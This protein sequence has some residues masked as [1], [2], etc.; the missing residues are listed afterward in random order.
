MP[1]EWLLYMCQLN[2]PVTGP[3]VLC[4]ET[5][6]ADP[7]QNQKDWLISGA[8]K[9]KDWNRL[10]QIP[11]PAVTPLSPSGPHLHTYPS[12]LCNICPWMQKLILALQMTKTPGDVMLLY[13]SMIPHPLDLPLVVTAELSGGLFLV[14]NHSPPQTWCQCCQLLQGD[15]EGARPGIMLLSQ[16]AAWHRRMIMLK[17]MSWTHQRASLRQ[18][19]LQYTYIILKEQHLLASTSDKVHVF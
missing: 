1:V 15:A 14:Q 19:T 5:S 12:N 17:A 2:S 6:H 10:K 18:P 16:R 11:I 13:C 3:Y 9:Y 8:Q 7:D 4:K